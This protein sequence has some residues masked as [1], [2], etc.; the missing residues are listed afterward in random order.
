M[1]QAAFGELTS[2]DDAMAGGSSL[3][4]TMKD[5]GDYCLRFL[6]E[7]PFEYA[8]HWVNL[9]NGSKTKIKCASRGC[10]LCAKGEEVKPEFIADVMDRKTGTLHVLEFGRQ[11]F[12][13]LKG[14]AKNSKWGDIRKYD[15][16]INKKKGR[17]P[18]TYMVQA[19]P[20]ISPLTDDEAAK[21]SDF[22][23]NRGDLNKLSAPI[24]NDGI[25]KRLSDLSGGGSRSSDF[26]SN[27]SSN[28]PTPKTPPA[29]EPAV[30]T[31][32]DYPEFST[33][34]AD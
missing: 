19:E 23:K 26:G 34:E 28:R 3:Y 8:I 29:E 2:W 10:I 1:V 6:N 5:D 20:P 33:S 22:C 4:M 7:R 11:I 25:K 21:A 14:Y 9:E 24:T 16:N 18:N 13:Q 27:T 30:S 31:E 17:K 32:F 12:D 15:V